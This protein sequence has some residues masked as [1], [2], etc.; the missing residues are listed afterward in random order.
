M[1]YGSCGLMISFQHG[2]P[3]NSIPILWYNRSVNVMIDILCIV[4]I[5][6]ATVRIIRIIRRAIEKYY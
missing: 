5:V 1:G 4:V 2:C 6:I 3:N